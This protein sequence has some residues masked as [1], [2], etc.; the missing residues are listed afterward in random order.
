MVRPQAGHSFWIVLRYLNR[1][2]FGYGTPRKL[3]ALLNE[4]YNLIARY[5]TGQINVY[6]YLVGADAAHGP[7]ETPIEGPE[8]R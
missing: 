4:T 1:Y 2:Q 3:P 5:H 8:S 7:P 6:R